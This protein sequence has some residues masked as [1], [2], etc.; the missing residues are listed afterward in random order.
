MSMMMVNF[1]RLFALIGLL[2]AWAGLEG[3]RA[4]TL[5]VTLPLSC[6][7]NEGTLNFGSVNVASGNKSSANATM[8]VYCA[9]APGANVFVCIKKQTL[10]MP[11]FPPG[12]AQLAY[13]I[14]PL[15]NTPV[16]ATGGSLQIGGTISDNQQSV[17][18]GGYGSLLLTNMLQVAYSATD[19]ANAPILVQVPIVALA[20]VQSSCFVTTNPLDFGSTSSLAGGQTGSTTIAV[21]CNFLTKYAVTLNGGNSNAN[22]PEQRKM[23]GDAGVANTIIYGLYYKDG[24]GNMVP[25]GSSL[26][27]KDKTWTGPPNITVYGRV[28]PQPTPAPGTYSD[29]IVVTLSF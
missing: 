4:V 25:W 18:A 5:P 19:C 17:P 6:T 20:V 26:G 7:F 2:A 9:G 28:P 13:D 3:A 16:K 14:T 29:T 11:G 1:G 21:R 12:A 24:S 22:D 8:T 27:S 10:N 15:V 23:T